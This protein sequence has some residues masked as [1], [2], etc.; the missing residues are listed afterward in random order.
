[1]TLFTV[2]WDRRVSPLVTGIYTAKS[3]WDDFM[4]KSGRNLLVDAVFQIIQVSR[5]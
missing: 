5:S 2:M 1:M 3:L 4:Q